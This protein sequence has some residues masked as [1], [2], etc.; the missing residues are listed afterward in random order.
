MNKKHRST[1][2][3]TG[4]AR[5]RSL[6]AFRH[7][8]PVARFVSILAAFTTA[9]LLAI[10]MGPAFAVHDNGMFELDGNTTQNDAT[11][12]PYDWEGLFN[13]SGNQIVT[14]DP[15]NGPVL[16]S[17]FIKDTTT[18][19]VS[20]FQSNKDIEPISA[21][22]CGPINNPT[23]KDD[24]QNSYAALIQVPNNAPDNAGHKVLYLG[25][26]RDSNNGTSFAG[27]WLLKNNGVGCNPP[28]SFTGGHTNGDILVVSDYTNGGG[29]QDVSVYKWVGGN[30]A[31]STTAN[32]QLIASGGVCD[33]GG[34]DDVC[35]IANSAT[36]TTP[37]A[38]T[39]HDTNT[40]VE[41]GIDLTNVLGAGGCFTTFLAET[42]SSDQLTATLKDYAGGQFNTCPP[43][44]LATQATPGGSNVA[45]G[46]SVTDVAT[47]TAV[48]GRPVP[49]GTVEFFLCQPSEVTVNV[50]CDD[51]D[52]TQVGGAIT[53][54]NGQAESASTSDTNVTGKYCW[55]AEY[56]PDTA[57]SLE[58]VASSHTNFGTE[59]FTVVKNSPDIATHI[60]V[61]G[62]G[63]GFTTLGDQATL[64][65]FAGDV[66]GETITFD[67]YG[68]YG[69]GVTPTCTGTPTF[70]TTGTLNASGVATTS[71]TY[72]PLAVGTFV[73]VAHYPGDS[74][75]NSVDGACTD[76]DESATIGG[77]DVSVAKSANPPGPVSAGDT[78]GFDITVTN[79]SN[80]PATGVHVTDTLPAGADGVTGGDLDW[81]LDPAYT[82]CT[83]TGAVGSE[84]L[85]CTFSEVAPG[86]MTPIHIT[87]ATSPADC[88]VVKNQA[89][90]TTTNGT[91]GSS[92][93]ATVSVLCPALVLSKTADA[94]SVTAGSQ[95]GFRVTASNSGAPGTGT[96][97]GVVIND[98]LP[99]GT[100]VNWTIA[101]GSASNC[102]IQGSP[103]SETLHCTA[104]DLAA[105]AS[106][107]V[108]VVS[109]T[110]NASC[111]VYPNAA[112]LTATNAPALHASASASV[113]GCVVVSPPEAEPPAALPNTG[114]PNAMAL[115]A[116]VL[117]L[118]GGSALVIGDR[119]RKHRS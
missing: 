26:E 81:S 100:G 34:N 60:Q 61:T 56:T 115:G 117:L 41:T 51:G 37:W 23:N 85:D 102:S 29:T 87:S 39:S 54:V 95:L 63:L 4:I 2:G 33:G 89:S 50:G 80:F 25:S 47:L 98:P 46:T 70:E 73:W 45:L 114:G 68:P 10:G 69:D 44:P 66:S 67:L 71:A 14:P 15:D 9:L 108:H 24:L 109:A 84:V 17:T 16:A 42:R 36:I 18:P 88:G 103:P 116:G 75:N 49:T 7:H 76:S 20:Y 57:G 105:G 8:N 82:G 31:N 53:V 92:T 38:P 112:S 52:G 62:T 94:A 64:T 77:V 99:A 91:G 74:L 83:I 97:H 12:P 21:W 19:D 104:V 1:S 78:I 43:A 111:K 101:A 3:P 107:T 40:F 79:N 55:R 28:G 11:P 119:R 30:T 96:A 110:T 65:G 106:F 6:L 27:F 58:Y 5:L 22:G 90:V 48:G 93:V 72:K 118:L 86:S 32:L 35:A 13:A 113:T 59:C